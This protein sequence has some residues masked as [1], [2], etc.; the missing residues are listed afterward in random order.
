MF[1]WNKDSLNLY[2]KW[3]LKFI[4]KFSVL[5]EEYMYELNDIYL[6]SFNTKFFR[7][8]NRVYLIRLKSKNTNL[9]MFKLKNW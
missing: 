7:N 1:F 9:R 5:L 3:G 8:L 6:L 4:I 2:S